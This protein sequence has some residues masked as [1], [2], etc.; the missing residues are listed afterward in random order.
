MSKL[1]IPRGEKDVGKVCPKHPE[2]KGERYLMSRHCP[3]CDKERSA[4]GHRALT[5][6][7]RE[8]ERCLELGVKLMDQ[9]L[10]Q[11]G[12][13]V[14]DVGTTNDFLMGARAA[15]GRRVRQCE[16]GHTIYPNAHFCR[17]CGAML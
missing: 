1:D 11:A 15:L 17:G 14:L 13:L 4:S 9:V 3:A 5:E 7:L 2:L 10:P 6:R 16:C 8:A 12:A